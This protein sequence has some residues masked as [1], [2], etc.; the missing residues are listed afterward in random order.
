VHAVAHDPQWVL[1]FS[2]SLQA[3]VQIDSPD[4]HTGVQTPA[5][6]LGLAPVTVVVHLLPQLLQLATSVSTFVHSGVQKL[7][8]FAAWQ[9]HTPPAHVSGA[10][11]FV[12]HVLQ[13]SLSVCRSV[14][15]PLQ[16]S[17]VPAAGLH[18]QA[19]P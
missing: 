5:S 18:L 17:G 14:Q 11:H 4:G 2:R 7:G 19:P 15:V 9:P 3:P 8:A 16:K 12:P 6:Q 1:L 10:V 13:L